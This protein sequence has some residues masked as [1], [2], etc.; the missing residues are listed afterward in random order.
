MRAALFDE[1]Q[2]IE[3]R[4]RVEAIREKLDQQRELRQEQE[5]SEQADREAEEEAEEQGSEQ[6][7]VFAIRIEKMA[8]NL[9][10]QGDRLLPGEPCDSH[11]LEF[12]NVIELEGTGVYRYPNDFANAALRNAV[13]ERAGSRATK[14]LMLS[15]DRDLAADLQGK[16][17]ADANDDNQLQVQPFATPDD[18]P[19]VYARFAAATLPQLE[20]VL[21]RMS[22]VYVHGLGDRGHADHHLRGA[23]LRA[24]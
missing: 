23:G 7:S 12:R 24:R 21:R 10:W 16:N 8:M 3:W 15:L 20:D 19:V 17:G 4:A 2:E 6:A 18:A 14:L 1:F 11:L 22:T 9:Q 5:R 13:D